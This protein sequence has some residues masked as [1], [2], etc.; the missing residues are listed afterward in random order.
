MT[1]CVYNDYKWQN[2]YRVG[3]DVVGE[4]CEQ[5]TAIG[6]QVP[7]EIADRSWLAR[8]KRNTSEA[9]EVMSERLKKG[10]DEEAQAIEEWQ[11]G[12][13]RTEGETVVPEWIQRETNAAVKAATG[14]STSGGG[15]LQQDPVYNEWLKTGYESRGW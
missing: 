12:A 14:Q 3:K 15:P 6:I 8:E 1:Q 13:A 10:V 2:G 7:K 4:I 9:I 11:A 5:G